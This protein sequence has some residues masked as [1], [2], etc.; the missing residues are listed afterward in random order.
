VII[1]DG[2]SLATLIKMGGMLT[3][4]PRGSSNSQHEVP[5]PCGTPL[6]NLQP[7]D[8]AQSG[9]LFQN[10][11]VLDQGYRNEKLIIQFYQHVAAQRK[12]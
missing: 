1:P 12:V 11:G 3:G 8:N 2:G 9:L 7:F 4:C 5:L 10:R 6:R